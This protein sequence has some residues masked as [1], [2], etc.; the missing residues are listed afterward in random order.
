MVEAVIYFRASVS[1]L[2]Y[3]RVLGGEAD[4]SGCMV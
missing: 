2:V 1:R 3:I 4:S